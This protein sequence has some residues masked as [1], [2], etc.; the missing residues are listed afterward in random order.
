MDPLTRRLRRYA[1]SQPEGKL[2]VIEQ[3]DDVD[4]VDDGKVTE[5]S[6]NNLR[7]S[8]EQAKDFLKRSRAFQGLYERLHAWIFPTTKDYI[9][10]ATL[11]NIEW[12]GRYSDLHCQVDW[13][14]LKYCQQEL[15]GKPELQRVLTITGSLNSAQAA[16]CEDY[17]KQTWGS[18]GTKSLNA[19][20]DGFVGDRFGKFFPVLRM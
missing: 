8:L 11:T 15:S 12:Q 17:V 2:D 7:D 14:L 4:D 19:I 10:H 5:A 9:R 6:L 1:N 20:V 18:W 13:E 3:I 16:S